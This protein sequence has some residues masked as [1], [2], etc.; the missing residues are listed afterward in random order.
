M[1]SNGSL[2]KSTNISLNGSL[3][4]E[5]LIQDECELESYLKEVEQQRKCVLS[6]NVDQPSNLLSSFWSHPATRS[7]GEVSPL[8]R[9]CAYQLAPTIGKHKIYLIPY[10][11]LRKFLKIIYI[12]I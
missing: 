9:R 5:D 1:Y 10:I 12:V 8:L 3:T 11:S 7:P 4:N 6:T 2:C